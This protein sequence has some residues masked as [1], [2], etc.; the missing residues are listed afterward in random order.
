MSNLYLIGFMAA[1]KSAVGRIVAHRLDRPFIDL[2]EV[3]TDRFGM[4]IEAVFAGPGE[5]AFRLAERQELERVGRLRDR[6]VAVGGGAF[7]DPANRAVMHAGDGQ[8][9]FLDVPWAA[10]AARLASASGGRPLYRSEEE[11][12]RLYR[13][14]R[15]DYA[16]ARWTVVL[17]GSEPPEEVAGRVVEVISGA[18][19]VT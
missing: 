13:A 9:V 11:A 6:V 7:C 10:L 3:L 18:S 5:A 1:G 2:D 8:T 4:T 12:E 19:C 14:R 16:A 17:D 15:P